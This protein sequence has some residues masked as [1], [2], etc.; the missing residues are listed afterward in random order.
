MTQLQGFLAEE[1]ERW[2]G[3]IGEDDPYVGQ[4]TVGI[5]M[6]TKTEKRFPFRKEKVTP[7]SKVEQIGFPGWK[8]QVGKGA[9]KTVRQK[10]D[11]TP[12]HGVD[13]QVFFKGLDPIVDLIV[14]FHGPLRRLARK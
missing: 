13:S 2:C 14:S 1:Y 8:S 6:E 10:T 12:D 7:E 4:Y 11:L 9:I 3:T 5:H